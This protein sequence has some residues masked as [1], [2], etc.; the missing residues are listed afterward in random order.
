V[1]RG[2]MNDTSEYY[3]FHKAYYQIIDWG[4]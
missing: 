3:K 2:E 4:G 1:F